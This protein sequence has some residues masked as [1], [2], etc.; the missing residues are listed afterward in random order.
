MVVVTDM[1]QR[2]HENPLSQVLSIVHIARAVIDII[3]N[4]AYVALV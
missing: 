4:A 2:P 1:P 3:V